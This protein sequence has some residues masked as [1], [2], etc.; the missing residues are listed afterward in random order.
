MFEAIVAVGTLV[1]SAVTYIIDKNE[2]ENERK[3]ARSKAVYNLYDLYLEAYEN[4]KDTFKQDFNKNE[5]DVIAKAKD[6]YNLSFLWYVERVALFISFF[7]FFRILVNIFTENEK[8]S[9]F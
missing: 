6:L 5:L 1:F 8:K 2:R 4:S 3:D 7:Y 9:R